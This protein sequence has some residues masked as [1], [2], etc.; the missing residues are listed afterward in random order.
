MMG[1]TEKGMKMDAE[2]RGL[3]MSIEG[4]DKNGVSNA[5][6]GIHIFSVGEEPP[7]EV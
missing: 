7:V 1:I 6:C 2:T 4:R 3:L 5:I